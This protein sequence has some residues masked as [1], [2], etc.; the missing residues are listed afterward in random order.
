MTT[1]NARVLIIIPAHNEAGYI[2]R[3]LE[4]FANQTCP[5]DALWI[6]DDHSSDQTASLV[7]SYTAKY[8]WIHLK[9][10]RSSEDHLPGTKVVQA[11]RSGLPANWESFDLIGKFDADIVLPPTYFENMLIQ[12]RSHPLLGMCAGH[13]YIEKKG[14]WVYE[15]IANRDHVR[16]PVKL[17][18]R[19]CYMAIG[20]LRPFIGWD[21]ADVLLARFH[22]FQVSTVPELR[23]KHLRPTGQGYSSRNARYQGLALYNLRYGWL[24]S[25]V[26]AGKMGLKRK[27]PMLPL[28]ALKAYWNAVF[29][30]KPR[31]LTP[32]EGD[33]VRKWRW[34]QI[35]GRL[36]KKL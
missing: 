12:F 18:S 20:G 26:A 3:C 31:M 8:P 2:G 28:H 10:H 16:G 19:E 1:G 30:K 13:L 21:S 33:F 27:K 36:F 6:V 11:F 24:L 35:N 14:V 7:Q 34:K 25:L 29:R 17:Y 4:S 22:G 32:Q 5:P 23:V 9:N 15:P